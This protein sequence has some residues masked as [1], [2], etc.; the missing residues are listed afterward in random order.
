[1]QERWVRVHGLQIRYLESGEG[2]NKHILFIHG[3]GSSADRWLDIPDALSLHFHAI[4]IDLPG[5]GGSDKPST[6]NYTIKEFREFIVSLMKEIRIGDGKTRIIGHSLGGYIAAEVAIEYKSLVQ[7]L[8]LIDSSGMLRQPT[9]LLKQYLKA[10]MNPS[11]VAVRKVFERMVADPTRVSSNLVEGFINRINHPNAKYAF[12][13]TLANSANTQ[14]GLSRLKMIRNI[15]TLI[16]WGSEDRVIPLEHSRL[17]KE[18][19]KDSQIAIIQD[20]GHAP[21]SEK[22]ALVCEILHKF[23][24]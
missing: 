21:F 13:L 9:P 7:K 3:L 19:I 17:F 12:R 1:M 6:M 14:I 20:A 15:P 23:L 10:A 5:F 24:A 4:A 11:K 22:P 2:N 8:V 16:V 18:T